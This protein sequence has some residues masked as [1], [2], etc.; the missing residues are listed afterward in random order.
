MKGGRFW[1]TEA[2]P[3]WKPQEY[4]DAEASGVR[5]D[6]VGWGV[7]APSLNLRPATW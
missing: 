4:F 3:E 5:A 1:L 6:L 7:R 2:D